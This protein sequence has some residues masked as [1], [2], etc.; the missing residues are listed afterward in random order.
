MKKIFMMDDNRY[1]I[2]IQPRFWY[3]NAENG[4]F[5]EIKVIRDMDNQD[6]QK[7]LDYFLQAL[8]NNREEKQ[9]AH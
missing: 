4:W 9:M 8:E 2:D 5:W 3:I 6:A 1:R 7:Y